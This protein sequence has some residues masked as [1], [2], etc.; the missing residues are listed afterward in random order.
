MK[1]FDKADDSVEYHT[2]KAVIFGDKL[3]RHSPEVKLLASVRNAWE[4]NPICISLTASMP[5]ESGA[6]VLHAEIL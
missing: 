2:A 1:S 6:V 3:K 5:E 4:A